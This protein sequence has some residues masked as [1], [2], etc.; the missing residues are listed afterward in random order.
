MCDNFQGKQTNKQTNTPNPHYK[1]LRGSMKGRAVTFLV[2]FEK[3]T[4]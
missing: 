2:G 3:L 4:F 1:I